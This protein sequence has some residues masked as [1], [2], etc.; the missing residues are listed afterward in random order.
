MCVYTHSN[1]IAFKMVWDF[2]V[3]YKT[4][5]TITDIH[6]TVTKLPLNLSFS[7]ATLS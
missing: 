5:V 7:F 4:T 6:F 1:F 3:F 2:V